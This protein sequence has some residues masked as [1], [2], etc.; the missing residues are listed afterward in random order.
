MIANYVILNTICFYDYSRCSKHSY[1]R[2]NILLKMRS[3]PQQQPLKMRSSP[4]EVFCRKEVLENL[5]KFKGRHL[6]WSLL[7]KQSYKLESY[8]LIKKRLRQRY[9]HENSAKFLRKPILENICERL[10]LKDVN[11]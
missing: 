9:F 5:T 6:G 10:L 11:F 8:I 3:K 2:I 4:L 7:F 1:S